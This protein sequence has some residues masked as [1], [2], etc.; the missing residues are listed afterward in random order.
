[1]QVTELA[2][3]FGVKKTP[4]DTTQGLAYFVHQRH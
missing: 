3:T 2:D 4:F 1:M